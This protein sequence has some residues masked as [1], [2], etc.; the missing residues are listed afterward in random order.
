[1]HMKPE[2]VE[3]KTRDADISR[4]YTK[5]KGIYTKGAPRKQ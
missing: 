2:V 3:H 5:G 4:R 1:M